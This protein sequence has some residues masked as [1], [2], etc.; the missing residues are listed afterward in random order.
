[1]KSPQA[2]RPPDEVLPWLGRTQDVPVDITT[3]LERLA[4]L[5]VRVQTPD[6]S[7]KVQAAEDAWNSRD[8]ERCAMAYTEDSIWRN[9]DQFLQGRQAIKDFLRGKWANESD[10]ALKKHYFCH[11]DNKI[12]VTF[13]YEYCTDGQWFRAYGNEHWTFDANGKMAVRN[14]SINDVKIDASERHI[15]SREGLERFETGTFLR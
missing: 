3:R 6:G 2:S 1:M 12:A 15:T 14:A 4:E 10:Y 13:Q 9:R 11:T 7:P 5:H 8:P